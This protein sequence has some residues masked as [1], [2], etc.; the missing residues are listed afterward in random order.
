MLHIV[1]LVT[2][3]EFANFVDLKQPGAFNFTLYPGQ[4]RSVY[5]DGS[6]EFAPTYY[7]KIQDW[8]VDP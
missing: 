5:V 2:K 7:I 3:N 8:A 4:R 1:G 6:S